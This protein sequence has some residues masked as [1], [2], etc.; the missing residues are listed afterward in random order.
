MLIKPLIEDVT[1]N[2]DD[3][4]NTGLFVANDDA[5]EYGI[6]QTKI[7]GGTATVE[8]FGRLNYDMPWALIATY[9]SST[10]ERVTL[11]PEMYAKVSNVVGATV[12]VVMLG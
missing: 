5:I 3:P 2:T 1:V 11:F 8:L 7:T 4:V 12:R 10:A 9:T 6:I